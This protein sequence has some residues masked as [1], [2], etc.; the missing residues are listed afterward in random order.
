MMNRVEALALQTGYKDFSCINSWFNCF[1][2][3]S[4]VVSKAIH[5][6][7]GWVETVVENWRSHW[8]AGGWLWQTTFSTWV[9]PHFFTRFC[10]VEHL[11]QRE[12]HVQKPNSARIELRFWSKCYWWRKSCLLLSESC[13]IPNASKMLICQKTYFIDVTRQP[14]GQQFCL[15]KT[16]CTR[17]QPR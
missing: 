10:P 3:Q 13:G 5:D 15:K 9:K 4:N 12:M 7:S 16:S 14:G 11:C 2:K 6:K 1:E 8:P 17:V